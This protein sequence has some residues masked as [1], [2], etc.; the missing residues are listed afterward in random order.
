MQT[1][2]AFL[3]WNFLMDLIVC[4]A[5]AIGC[6]RDRLGSCLPAALLGTVYAV[7]VRQGILPAGKAAQAF[8]ALC[9]ACIAAC[10]ADLGQALRAAGTL[11]AASV[12]AA[13]AQLL[14]PGN[15]IGAI[16]A[17]IAG[18]GLDLWLMR[19]RRVRMQTWDVHLI[20]RTGSGRARFRALVDTGNRLH[21]PIS[22]L[23][24][25][26]VEQRALGEALPAGFDAR[27]AAAQ[28]PQGWRMVG[29]GVL[30]SA[31][32][33]ACFRPERLLVRC[34]GRWLLAPDIWI[35]VY[36]GRIPGQVQALAPTVIG[37]IRAE[38]GMGMRSAGR[39][40]GA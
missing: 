29:Y 24:V 31:G 2:E 18:A 11:L 34:E 36:P 7:A 4:A 38:K 6:G 14:A 12:F 39:K 9:M 33:M 30:G 22:G 37:T 17:A 25:M 23:P 21:E 20:L 8:A 13:G 5:A 32:K 28:L 1:L 10:P 40:Q 19:T 35:A 15:T 16:V 3:C 27:T 26:I